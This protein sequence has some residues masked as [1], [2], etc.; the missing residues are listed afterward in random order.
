MTYPSE[1]SNVSTVTVSYRG[2]ICRVAKKLGRS[3]SLVSMVNSGK[4]KS[5]RVSAELIKERERMRRQQEGA[6]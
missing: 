2:L 4:V 6:A 1:Q 3:Q 5:A